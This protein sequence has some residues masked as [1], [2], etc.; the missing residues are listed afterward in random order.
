MV[1]D[2]RS[3]PSG[4]EK[5]LWIIWRPRVLFTRR[6]P[7]PEIPLAMAAGFATLKM[8]KEMRK[9]YDALN[10]RTEHL[11]RDIRQ[12]FEKKGLPVSINQAGSMFTLFFTASRVTDLASAQRCDTSLFIRFFE[13]MMN[14]GIYLAPSPFEASFLSFAHTPGDIKKTL[15]II[16]AVLQSL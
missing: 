11:C 13:G 15:E 16:D 1:G 2:S 12:L 7:F 9:E 14:R 10:S 8:L 6:A 3:A 5:R 4:A